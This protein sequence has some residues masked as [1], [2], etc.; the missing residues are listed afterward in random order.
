MFLHPA[1]QKIL[2]L[3]R[4]NHIGGIMKDALELMGG[5]AVLFSGMILAVIIAVTP[6]VIAIAV[7]YWMLRLMGVVA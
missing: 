3:F 1:Q 7:L 4:E 5:F 6:F 2:T